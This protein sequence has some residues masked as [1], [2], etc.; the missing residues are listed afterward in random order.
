MKNRAR[1]KKCNTVIESMH[2]TDYQECTCHEISVYGGPDLMQCGALSWSNFVR[3]DDAGNEIIVTIKDSNNISKEDIKPEK[4]SKKSLKLCVDQMIEY[5]ERM[6]QYAREG[7]VTQ[8]DFQTL[9]FVLSEFL[10][11]DDPLN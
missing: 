9:L 4:P 6:P 2:R 10:S 1:C 5:I 11:L 8:Y 7:Y 3:V